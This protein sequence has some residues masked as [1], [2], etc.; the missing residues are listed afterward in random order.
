MLFKKQVYCWL[1][2]HSILLK[3]IHPTYRFIRMLFQEYPVFYYYKLT[4]VFYAKGVNEIKRDIPVVVSLT[5]F[6][7]RLSK[8]S[9]CLETLLRQ[10]V[11]PDYITLCIAEEDFEKGLPSAIYQCVERG[12]Q[13]VKCTD[14]RSYKKIIPTLDMYPEAVI[15][16]ADDDVFYPSGWLGSL[17]EAYE[18]EPNVVHCHRSYYMKRDSEGHFLDYRKWGDGNDYK[19][20]S[21]LDVFPVGV[22]GVLYPPGCFDKRVKDKDTFMRLCPTTDDIWL[23]AMTLL[24]G[25]KCRQTECYP[26]PWIAIPP[27][28]QHDGLYQENVYGGKND[29]N[30]KKVFTHF[31]I[32]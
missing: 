28:L 22:G 11:R 5:S 29:A 6:G 10:K 16:T 24:Q 12:I 13:V 8:V 2:K 7:Q 21:A 17:L 18:Q 3:I 4:S 25:V 15:V 23:K 27:Q 30:L 20:Q 31:N 9:I 1:Q 32:I 14:L 26:K 19:T